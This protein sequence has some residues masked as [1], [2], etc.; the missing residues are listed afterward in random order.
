MLGIVSNLASLYKTVQFYSRSYKV[1]TREKV[2]S[3]TAVN[4]IVVGSSLW[5]PAIP[6]IIDDKKFLRFDKSRLAVAKIICAIVSLFIQLILILK[7]FHIQKSNSS[8]G[9]F[10][11]SWKQI[12]MTFFLVM[13][14]G[15]CFG[16]LQ[17]FRIPSEIA[18]VLN[19]SNYSER[20]HRGKGL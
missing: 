1:S 9:V 10:T 13:F 17:Q 7:W 18:C 15:T 16:L 6:L 20:N 19:C 12:L 11:D 8:A 14:I 3:Y 5:V 4:H 2:S